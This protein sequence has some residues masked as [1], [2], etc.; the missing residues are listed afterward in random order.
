MNTE[1]K[2]QNRKNFNR[3]IRLYEK[4]LNRLRKNIIY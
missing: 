1:K 2:L 4:Y 3:T